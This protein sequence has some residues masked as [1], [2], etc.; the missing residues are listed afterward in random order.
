MINKTHFLGLRLTPKPGDVLLPSF[1]L[2]DIHEAAKD[3]KITLIN[4]HRFICEMNQHILYQ[5]VFIII[6]WVMIIGLIVSVIGFI[7]LFVSY[8]LAY[9]SIRKLTPLSR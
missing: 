7:L 8:I 2:C 3:I 5:Y 9:V 1:A 4:K 6:W